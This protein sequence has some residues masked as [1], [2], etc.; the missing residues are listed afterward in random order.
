[1]LSQHWKALRCEQYDW[2]NVTE[3]DCSP[4][5]GRLNQH[6]PERR[7]WM[8]V[9]RCSCPALH[10]TPCEH[11]EAAAAES[12][13]EKGRALTKDRWSVDECVPRASQKGRGTVH[14]RGS[15]KIWLKNKNTHTHTQKKLPHP[16]NSGGFVFV[17]SQQSPILKQRTLL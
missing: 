13:N 16:T 8:C 6:T 3:G 17:A 10:N 1:M 4:L 2:K 5:S 15:T 7:R 11:E 9:Q 12:V 14:L